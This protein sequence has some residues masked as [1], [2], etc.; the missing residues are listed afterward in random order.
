MSCRII[1]DGVPYQL[2]EALEGIYLSREDGGVLTPHDY[3]SISNIMCIYNHLHPEISIS[4]SVTTPK[5]YGHVSR[6]LI[7]SEFTPPMSIQSST[8]GKKTSLKERISAAWRRF[9]AWLETW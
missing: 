8:A 4:S 9:W 1:H 3:Q 2:D 6:V 5:D 7:K